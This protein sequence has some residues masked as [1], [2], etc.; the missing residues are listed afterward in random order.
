MGGQQGGLVG[1]RLDAEVLLAQHGVVVDDHALGVEPGGDP[2]ALAVG[3][4]EAQAGEDALHV[5]G[6]GGGR[7]LVAPGL[8]AQSPGLLAAGGGGRLALAADRGD[9]VDHR[10]DV[11]LQS[12]QQLGDLGRDL[13]LRL[14]QQQVQ[15]VPLAGDLPETGPDSAQ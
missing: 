1:L 11:G 15:P 12:L 8:L 9:R 14:P 7:L 10:G 6:Q 3:T 4:V 13:A 5:A 2:P